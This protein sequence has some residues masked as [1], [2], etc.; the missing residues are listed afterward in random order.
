MNIRRFD[1]FAEWNR[2]TGLKKNLDEDDAEAY[3]IAVAKV[4]AARKFTGYEPGQ[5]RDWRQ[6]ARGQ[7]A[8]R[9]QDG[10]A[11]WWEHMGSADE[12]DRKVVRRMGTRFYSEVFAPAVQAAWDRGEKYEELRDRLR[13][14]W[15]A[16]LK[17]AASE[18]SS[19]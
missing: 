3:G 4:V 2:L 1:V 9:P 5:V 18:R 19:G 10:E 12:F 14:G 13:E 16:A 17:A 8:E 15:N 11:P 7:E 6:R